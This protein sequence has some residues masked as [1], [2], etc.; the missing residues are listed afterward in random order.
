M[1]IICISDTHNHH[2]VLDGQL[3]AADMIIHAGDIAIHGSISEIQEF[4]NWYSQLPYKYKLFVGGNHDGE[5]EHKLNF[6][7]LPDN[8]IYLE[9]ES[10]VIDGLT[11]WGSPVSPPYRSFGFMWDEL[12]RK[13]LYQQIPDKCD[14]VINH[15]PP[16]GILDQIVEGTNVGCA[17]F[18]ERLEE[19]NPK[20]VICGHIH[21]GYGITELAGTTYVNAS[22][23][24]RKYL[25]INQPLIVEI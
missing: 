22:I 8:I 18:R 14:I 6:L 13:E 5:L 7:E 2:H 10:I 3:P 20:L 12:R 9:N 11:I 21:E 17:I 19:I 15:S 1:K 16:Y 23:M 25:P 4:V 24:S